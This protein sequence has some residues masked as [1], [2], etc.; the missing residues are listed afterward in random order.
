[1]PTRSSSRRSVINIP[2]ACA[3]R[4]ERD[5]VIQPVDISY[6]LGGHS[7]HEEEGKRADGDKSKWKPDWK[8]VKATIEF[9]KATGGL[10]FA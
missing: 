1:M 2:C 4:R 5:T 3:S 9:A 8:V 7:I 6:A 10:Q